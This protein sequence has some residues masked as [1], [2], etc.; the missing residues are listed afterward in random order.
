MASDKARLAKDKGN[1]AFKVA[2]Y[3]TA[4]GHYTDAILADSSDHTFFLNRAA[5]YLKLGK[6][7]DAEKDCTE[8]LAL[9]SNNVKALFRRGQARRALGNLDDAQADLDQALALDP[10]NESVKNEILELEKLSQQRMLKQRSKY[11]AVDTPKNT[12]PKRRRVPIEIVEGDVP[13]SHE[14]RTTTPLKTKN[15]DLLQPVSSRPLKKESKPTTTKA[16]PSKPQTFVDAKQAREESKPVRVSG[17]IFRPTGNHTVV[18]RTPM[19]TASSMRESTPRPTP[20]DTSTSRFPEPRTTLFQF[21]KSWES[22]P[23][24]MDKWDLIRTISP[25]SIPALFQVSLEPELLKSILHTFQAML[26]QDPTPDTRDSAREY[27]LAF[28]KVQRF[29]TV[30]LFMDKQER[31]LFELLHKNV[32]SAQS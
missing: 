14:T 15:T 9:S 27:L 28:T 12:T 5:A 25:S 16:P 1:A 30:M 2:N 22:L 3:P 6:S 7:E 18:T 31:Q 21:T 32:N 8:V 29:G 23:S 19:E 26:E 13:P 11:T 4:I 20:S 17:G 10:A 24:D